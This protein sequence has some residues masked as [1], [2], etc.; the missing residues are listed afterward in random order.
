MF[1]RIKAKFRKKP[2]Q[3]PPKPSWKETVALMND[4][5]PSGFT[6][7]DEVLKVFYNREKDRRMIFFKSQSGYFYYRTERL[8]P[9]DDEE[10][11]YIAYEKD[12]LPAFWS[13]SED[14]ARSFFGSE[15]DLLKEVKS[16][17][18]YI[19]FFTDEI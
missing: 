18:D 1:E 13:P 15:Q 14:T 9:F 3:I 16:A 2:T 4:E 17:A 10:W 11:S 19:I 8:I 7:A 5:S 12:A 6:D